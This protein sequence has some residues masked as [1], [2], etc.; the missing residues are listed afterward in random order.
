MHA[1]ILAGGKGSRLR[2]YTTVL[3]K[4]LMPVNGQ[5]IL[6]IIMRQ[7]RYYG[8]TRVTVALG[9]LAHLVRAVLGNG[10][11][12]GLTVDYSVEDVPLGTSGPLALIPNLSGTFLVMNG[13]IL[14]N[15]NFLDLLDFH[16][17]QQSVLTIASHCRKVDIDYGVLHSKDYHL[18][19]YD[20]KPQ[21]HYEV[22]MGIYVLNSSVL[23]YIKP[24]LYMDIPDLISTLI[25]NGERVTC[26]PFDDIWFD[27]GRID[28]FHMVDRQID[29]LKQ[30]IPFFHPSSVQGYSPTPSP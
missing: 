4:P 24:G 1:I 17:K 11:N 26:F 9:H 10:E 13:D 3:P 28:D 12:H 23:R 20:E 22:S 5:P 27:L 7:L 15:M 16:E 8:F 6:E 2:P 18:F 25:N 14:T 30:R 29:E 21:I 19:K